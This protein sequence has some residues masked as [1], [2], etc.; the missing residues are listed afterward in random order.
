MKEGAKNFREKSV[1]QAQ[2]S[3]ILIGVCVL[4]GSIFPRGSESFMGK[5]KIA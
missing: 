3:L 1:V 2:N 5:W 4:G